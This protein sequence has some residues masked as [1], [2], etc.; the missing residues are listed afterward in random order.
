MTTSRG[1]NT[2]GGKRSIGD[3]VVDR[4]Q[5]DSDEAIVVNTLPGVT[6]T[7]W[8][9][10]GRGSVAADNPAYPADDSVVI[11]V[12][13]EELNQHFDYYAGSRPLKLTQLNSRET[14]YYAFPTSRLRK[15]DELTP[16]KVPLQTI[17]PSP[18]HARN[19]S[20]KTNREFIAEIRQEGELPVAPLLRSVDGAYEILNGHKR[21]WV[22][23]IAGLSTIRA[24]C[25]DVNDWKAAKLFSRFHLG[26]S[27]D[28]DP[29]TAEARASALTKLHDR[30]GDK[31]AQLHGVSEEDI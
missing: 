23:H 26:E 15:I 24:N 18:Y 3:I 17:R 7:D 25:I 28:G 11:I 21:V 16:R 30:W 4:E 13:R 10:P 6:A 1:C 19:F 29:Y 22:A 5:P 14:C 12:F 31:I 27:A 20:V 8:D 2:D 9:V